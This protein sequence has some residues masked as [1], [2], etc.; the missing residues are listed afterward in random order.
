MSE[1]VK[2]VIFITAVCF[3][4]L[5]FLLWFFYKPIKRFVW[6]HNISRMFYQKVMAVARNED[7]YLVNNLSLSIGE[8]KSVKI[9][10]ILGGDK[11]IYVI[12]DYYFD[13]ALNVKPFDQTWVYFKR[14]AKKELIANPLFANRFA[15]ERLSIASG[16]SSSFLIGI[17]LI[18]DDCFLNEFNNG[19]SETLL[20]PASKLEKLIS[21]CEKKEVQP[22]VKEEL[23]QTIH[24]LHELG[25][26]NNDKQ[27]N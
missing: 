6:R 5:L 3:V 9:D 18:N 23:W 14:G 15:T 25:R 16:I 20:V 2:L 13:G 24:D 19:E 8:E 17:V 7:F 4:G 1:Q 11:F 10:H 12:T 21:A 27:S 26:K 22:F